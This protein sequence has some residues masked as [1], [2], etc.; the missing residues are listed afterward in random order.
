MDPNHGYRCRGADR[1]ESIRL[2][3]GRRDLRRNGTKLFPKEAIAGNDWQSITD[4]CR[5]ALS[6]IQK[7]RQV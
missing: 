5:N 6:I 2:V 3:Q 4:L 1:G 7:Y